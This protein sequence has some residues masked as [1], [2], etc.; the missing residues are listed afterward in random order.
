[1]CF[2]FGMSDG[3]ELETMAGQK[4][5]LGTLEA[6]RRGQRSAC[7]ACSLGGLLEIKINE[8]QFQERVDMYQHN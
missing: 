7:A 5:Q 2:P 3:G 4:I 1:M 6:Q 8:M